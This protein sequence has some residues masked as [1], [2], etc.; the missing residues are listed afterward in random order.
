MRISTLYQTVVSP[1]RIVVAFLSIVILSLIVFPLLE[2][3]LLPEKSALSFTIT[4]GSDGSTPEIVETTVTSVLENACAGL[5]KLKT[6]RSE[7]EA[8]Q[9]TIWLAF[10]KGADADLTRFELLSLIRRIYPYLPTKTS[11]PIVSQGN[12]EETEGSPFMVIAFSP[13]QDIGD[14]SELIH[15]TIEKEISKVE[16][17]REMELTGGASTRLVVQYNLNRIRFWELDP[18]EL[19]RQIRDRYLPQYPGLSLD[20][21]GNQW[22]IRVNDPKIQNADLQSLPLTCPDG[23]VL[24]LSDIASVFL[25]EHAPENIFRING[26][27]SLRL[28]IY[29]HKDQNKIVLA[30]RIKTII[31]N[32]EDRSRGKIKID[33]DHD[34]SIFLK[35]ALQEIGKRVTLSLLILCCFVII[36]YRNLK[37]ILILFM[38]LVANFCLTL[39]L[40]WIIQIPIHLYTI[41]AVAISFGLVLDHTIT[42]FDHYVRY[43]KPVA[44]LP[45][46][47]STLCTI[48]ALSMVFLLNSEK[49]RLFSDFS[50]LIIL[51]LLCSLLVSLLLIPSLI[52]LVKP[53]NF[54]KIGPGIETISSRHISH[55]FIGRYETTIAA[56]H[57]FRH[58]VL[59]LLIL[60]FGLPVFLL[61]EKW[62]GERWYHSMY[63][64]TIGA[65]TY[66]KNAKPLVDKWLGGALRIFITDVSSKSSFQNPE[67]RKL[68]VAIN[69]E[70]GSSL[71]QLNSILT[72]LESYLLTVKGINRITCRADEPTKGKIEIVFA[73]NQNKLPFLLKEELIKKS[74][75]WGGVKWN[76]YGIGQGFSNTNQGS[77]PA[78]R[79]LMKGYNFNALKEEANRLQKILE[80]NTRVSKVNIDAR[81]T[82]SQEDIWH[83]ELKINNKLMNF[84]NITSEELIGLIKSQENGAT[85]NELVLW[86]NRYLPLVIQSNETDSATIHDMLFTPR[87]VDSNQYIYLDRLAQIQQ[88]QSTSSI[89]RENRQYQRILSFDFL[90]PYEYGKKFL[91]TT[92]KSFN[93][94][95]KPGYSTEPN[96]WSW[97]VDRFQNSFLLILILVLVFYIIGCVLFES[98]LQPL[99]II[100][101]IPFS[102]LGVFA[103]FSVGGFSFD[104]GG[105]ASLIF[106][107]GLVISSAFFIINEYNRNIKL[108]PGADK[109]AILLHVYSQRYK[110]ILLSAVTTISGLIPFLLGG[111]NQVFW[112]S[113]A[114]GTI[115]GTL[116]SLPGIFFLLPLLIWRK[117]KK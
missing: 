115:S 17:I 95:L 88:T 74:I 65:Q 39:S 102:Y 27:N 6:I 59:F 76:I 60:S 46:L 107:G 34:D 21:S 42:I 19:S 61:P 14:F 72:S 94:T 37:I 71:T 16:G 55:G 31:K 13:L 58:L 49:V 114:V 35:E 51:S 54:S 91:D 82:F 103:T 43:R 117:N 80:K 15:Q 66:Q 9:G 96:D 53:K 50:I 106:L 41:A 8:N 40:V 81:S 104:Q 12:E 38:S 109:N 52:E 30:D 87:K 85:S 63:N 69:M 116:F 105:Y 64:K 2:I 57:R 68:F 93:K 32:S 7:S 86:E 98:L 90:A 36:F 25:E 3:D 79:V 112:Y 28:L 45:I 26:K 113:L 84:Y 10:E 11:Y 48:S 5:P 77:G 99:Y 108:Y 100:V 1:F 101:L 67:E 78:N 29:G 92:L 97:Q 75:K 23:R 18:M 62:E 44:L 20:S 110:T 56:L 22:M 24:K 4:I 47:G 111:P 70:Y 83:Y 89:I 73:K 33:I